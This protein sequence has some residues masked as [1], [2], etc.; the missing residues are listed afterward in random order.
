MDISSKTRERA[1]IQQALAQAKRENEELHKTIALL[2]DD[3]Y[4]EDLARLRLGLVYPG[5][6]LFKIVRK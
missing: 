5:E 4:V 3:R 2:K 6:V 1:R